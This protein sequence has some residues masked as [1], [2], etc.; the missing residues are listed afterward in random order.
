MQNQLKSWFLKKKKLKLEKPL[1]NLTKNREKGHV[2]C[3]KKDV[4][5]IT[6]SLGIQRTSLEIAIKI[7][8][9]K[10]LGNTEETEL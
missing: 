1:A 7:L 2:I 9:A 8:Y 4:V 10:K 3:W 5:S 6:V